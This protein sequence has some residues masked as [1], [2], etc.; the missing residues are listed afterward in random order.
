MKYYNQTMNL[1]SDKIITDWQRD[2]SVRDVDYESFDSMFWIE[3]RRVKRSQFD[4]VWTM[5]E[6]CVSRKV[7]HAEFSPTRQHLF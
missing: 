4:A 6:C 5:L 3:V 7:D 2:S 1:N